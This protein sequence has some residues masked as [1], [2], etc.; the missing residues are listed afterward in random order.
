MSQVQSITRMFCGCTG[1]NV[2]PDINGWNIDHIK[3]RLDVFKGC[4]TKLNIP[5]KYL[6]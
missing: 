4:S 2:L 5:P 3:E 1:L 6:G